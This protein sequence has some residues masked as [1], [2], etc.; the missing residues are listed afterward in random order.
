MA[1]D[2]CCDRRLIVSLDSMP[3]YVYCVN[4]KQPLKCPKCGAPTGGD[5]WPECRDSET[6]QPSSGLDNLAGP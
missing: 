4:C 5:C 2:P 6:P 1:D 3:P